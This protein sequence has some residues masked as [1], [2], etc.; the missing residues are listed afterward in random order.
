MVV[1]TIANSGYGSGLPTQAVIIVQSNV[2]GIWVLIRQEN[3]LPKK[4][5]Y[6]TKPALISKDLIHNQA[7]R[8]NPNNPVEISKSLGDPSYNKGLKTNL[9]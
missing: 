5:T 6:D 2:I 4:K 3:T 7:V 9:T 1:F 8:R